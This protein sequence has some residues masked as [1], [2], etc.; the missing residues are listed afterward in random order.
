[1]LGT[2]L[3]DVL[4]KVADRRPAV[5]L[6]RAAALLAEVCEVVCDELMLVPLDTRSALTPAA[7][8]D[9][10][11]VAAEPPPPEGLEAAAPHGRP[12]AFPVK[13][14]RGRVG[15]AAERSST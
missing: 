5:E 13:Q 12:R 7:D 10:R 6:E 11:A 14:A 8:R 4:A 9:G 1:V 3:R 2:L 15:L